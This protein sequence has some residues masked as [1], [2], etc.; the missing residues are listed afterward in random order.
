MLERNTIPAQIQMN[1]IR[2]ST[3]GANA[4]FNIRRIKNQNMLML[5]PPG[6][7]PDTTCVSRPVRPALSHRVLRALW[8]AGFPRSPGS[9][10]AVNQT[11][12]PASGR[13][14]HPRNRGH[15]RSTSPGHSRACRAELLPPNLLSDRI[16]TYPEQLQM[17]ASVITSS[18]ALIISYKRPK[19]KDAA[20]KKEREAAAPPPTPSR[21]ICELQQ[22]SPDALK[23]FL[24]PAGEV[25]D[26]RLVDA[27]RRIDPPRE[28]VQIAA[29]APQKG[30][31]LLQFRQIQ[32]D[33]IT[34]QRHLPQIG[35]PIENAQRG[36]F[37]LNRGQLRSGNPKIELYIPLAFGPVHRSGSFFLWVAGAF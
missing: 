36:H 7:V 9:L 11:V 18:F 8:C 4:T 2:A 6:A 21:N 32:L 26:V 24:L 17:S 25:C 14:R 1:S 22:H 29:A 20:N 23:Q 13:G 5:L 15:P 19:S 34:V 16:G 33:R 30:Q 3:T 37:V 35:F 28:L 10:P 27:A 12:P 31:Q